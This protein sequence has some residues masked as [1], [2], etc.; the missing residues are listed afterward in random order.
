MRQK[1]MFNLL[2]LLLF[3]YA[4]GS[5][6]HGQLGV[7]DDIELDGAGSTPFI[8]FEQPNGT[9]M[10]IVSSED[11][12]GFEVDD[13]LKIE[14]LRHA[15][16][17]Y[18]PIQ[19]YTELTDGFAEVG[20]DTSGGF[21]VKTPGSSR[22][23]FR[24]LNDSWINSLTVTPTGV[25]VYNGDPQAALHV[26]PSTPDPTKILVSENFGEMH[27]EMLEMQNIGSVSLAFTDTSINSKWNLGTTD[28]GDIRFWKETGF[29]D[30][31]FGGQEIS[32]YSLDGSNSAGITSWD[33]NAVALKTADEPLPFYMN[34][35]ARQGSMT[36]YEEGV[37]IGRFQAQAPLHV[38]ADG[39]TAFHEATILVENDHEETAQRDM[40]ELVNNGGSRFSFTDT[41]LDSRWFFTSD[42]IGRFSISLDGTG[43][44]E[45]TI[46]QDGR[47]RMGPGPIANFDLLPN[48]NLQIQGT[49]IQ[50]SDKNLKTSF[51]EINTDDILEHLSSM[52]VTTWQFKNDDASHRHMGPTAQDF[53]LAFGLGQDDKTI[54][55]VDGIGVSL[56]AA[57]GLAQ[58]VSE[59]TKQL[60]AKNSRIQKLE[61][62][63]REQN[64]NLR[65]QMEELMS[66]VKQLEATAI[67]E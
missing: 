36:I 31:F 44:P 45:F 26:G 48:G 37:G 29:G 65:D 57:K 56:A 33:G 28:S 21:Y 15:S 7:F 43:G 61:S 8:N 5:Q 67:A 66:R 55:P 46:Q 42:A 19:F 38:F 60:D 30:M 58:K 24:V 11:H 18:T 64:E 51:R 59:L 16:R 32:L 54:A 50:S 49:L 14:Q 13:V 10:R 47:V 34:G 3:S 63:L 62:A 41:S 4:N 40:F 9:N 12:I 53:R 39:T 2:F 22:A 20:G 27:R 25:G 35:D 23:Q 1:A 17:Y 6:A 52:P